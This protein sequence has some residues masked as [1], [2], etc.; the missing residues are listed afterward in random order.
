MGFQT[1]MYSLQEYLAR[2]TNGEIQVASLSV[3]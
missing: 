2:T 1:P 3:V